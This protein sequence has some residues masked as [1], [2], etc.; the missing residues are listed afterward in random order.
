MSKF[1]FNEVRVIDGDNKGAVYSPEM[2]IQLPL[3]QRVKM[4]I[5]QQL[6]FYN[7]QLEVDKSA[8]LNELRKR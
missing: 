4:I 3:S 7:D 5:G 8:A 2:F 6:A 1:G